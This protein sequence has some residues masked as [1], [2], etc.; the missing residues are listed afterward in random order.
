MPPQAGVGPLL[1]CVEAVQIP[2]RP[3]LLA[4]VPTLERFL[5]ASRPGGF[6]SPAGVR[7]YDHCD[8]VSGCAGLSGV[9]E[10]ALFRPARHWGA[11]SEREIEG[12]FL[13]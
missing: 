13:H 5:R 12:F 7:G 4:T 10:S 1:W 2:G 6:E 3:L 11:V 8:S 9:R